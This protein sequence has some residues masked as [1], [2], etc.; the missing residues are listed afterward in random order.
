MI[1]WAKAFESAK[2]RPSPRSSREDK[3]NYAERLSR[4]LA[5]CIANGLRRDFPEIIPAESGDKHE[6]PALGA[7]G[8]KR[9]DVNYSTPELGLGLGISIKTVETQMGR[10]LKSL[11]VSLAEFRR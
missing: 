3:K 5:L 10:A 7:R 1:E 8:A 2:P 6:S 9:L 11:R 4:S